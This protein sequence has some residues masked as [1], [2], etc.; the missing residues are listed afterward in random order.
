M[1]SGSQ[2]SGATIKQEREAQR[3]AKVEAFKQKRARE[4]R[5]RRIGL[6]ASIVGG[7][8]VVT[9]LVLVI[10]QSYTPP[11]DPADI[12]IESVENFPGIGANH[13]ETAVDYEGIYGMTPPAG[14]DHSGAWL[15]CGIY[16]QPQP[17]ENVVHSLEHG[18]LWITYDPELV[19]DGELDQLRNSVPST[20]VVLSPYPGLPA[21]VV[22]SGWAN[23]VQLSG[24]DDE[25]LDS[26][27]AK[28]WKGG[29]AP[30]AG[31]SCSGA[32]EGTGR[33]G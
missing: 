24:V 33:V 2:R 8:T 19:T 20:Y 12:V 11:V 25:R 10:V 5:N 6:T 32:L 30:E 16:D 22:A 26:F 7:L 23:Q 3:A 31:A 21:P 15:N 13:V 14:G 27:V 18:A 1:A 4:R 29:D 9:L 17:S 28:F